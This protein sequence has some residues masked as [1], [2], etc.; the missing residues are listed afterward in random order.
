[1]MLKEHHF[2]SKFHF[3]KNYGSFALTENVIIFEPILNLVNRR[4]LGTGL[5][6]GH[7]MII[8]FS[9]FD[10]KYRTKYYD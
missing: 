7:K 1:M 2:E 5:F 10:R 3:L 8:I 6:A 9:Y 4:K